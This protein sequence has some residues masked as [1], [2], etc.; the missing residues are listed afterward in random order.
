[1]STAPILSTRDLSYAYRRGALVLSEIDVSIA[2]GERVALVG[3]NGAGKST[4]CRLLCA[5]LTPRSGVV[6]LDGTPITSV[7]LAQRAAQLAY[8]APAATFG[9]PLSVRRVIEL[10]RRQR[11]AA[12]EL[13]NETLDRFELTDLA[14]RNAQTLSGGQRQRVSLARAWA[15]LA[16]SGRAILI[17]DEPTSAMDPR[18]A[19]LAFA[20][21]H[22]LSSR[23]VAVLAALH[24]LSAAARFAE[25]ALLLS[26][27]GRPLACGSSENALSTDRLGQ[28]FGVDFVRADTAA[29]RV[30]IASKETTWDRTTPRSSSS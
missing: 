10:S 9:A 8:I 17:A 6:E 5:V 4:F 11:P 27:E 21:L 3:P 30:L 16:D 25:S 24:D 19:Q 29:G 26:A 14:E 22:D 18:Y 12:P 20:A 23:G 1:M 7:P 13:I 2:A 15:Q 28:A